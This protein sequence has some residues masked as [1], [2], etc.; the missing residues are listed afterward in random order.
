MAHRYPV[1]LVGQEGVLMTVNVAR[2]G[3]ISVAYE[4]AGPR[5]GE[6][7]LLISGIGSQLLQW[8]PGFADALVRQGFRV[9]R[10][11]NRDVGL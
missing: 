2:D 11:D 1:K 3:D 10:L 9:A 8:P 6:P 4:T 7:L 5:E